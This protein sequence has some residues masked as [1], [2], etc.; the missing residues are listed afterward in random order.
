MPRAFWGLCREWGDLCETLFNSGRDES[1]S[2][3]MA[4]PNRSVARAPRGESS[5]GMA[6]ATRTEMGASAGSRL[7]ERDFLLDP[8][9]AARAKRARARRVHAIQ[10]PVLRLAGLSAFALLVAVFDLSIAGSFHLASYL[11][12]VGLLLAYALGS[13]LVLWRYYGRTGRKRL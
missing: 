4:A 12:F 1:A 3:H 7:I 11:R 9:E 6:L 8:I 5:R 10:L 13:W 2:G